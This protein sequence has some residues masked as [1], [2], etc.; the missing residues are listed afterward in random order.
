MS[1]DAIDRIGA[2]E[3]NLKSQLRDAIIRATNTWPAGHPP[4]E[5]LDGAELRQITQAILAIREPLQVLGVQITPLWRETHGRPETVA[6]QIL[7]IV[8][9]NGNS[10]IIESFLKSTNS[11]GTLHNVL[12][13]LRRFAVE[14]LLPGPIAGNDQEAQKTVHNADFTMVVWYGTPHRFALGVQSSAVKALW[15]EWQ[16][17]GL[18]LHGQTIRDAI[19][20]ERDS[21]R[22]DKAFRGH[23][24]Y[25]TMIQAI[26]DGH[27]QLTPPACQSLPASR[28]SE[29]NAK[30]PSKSRRRPL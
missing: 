20:P 23:A 17:T 2:L 27:Y 9:G 7:V 3:L 10:D 6:R 30:S 4:T 24:A 11:E 5:P 25:G 28:K 22:M 8:G 13:S 19:D 1:Q 18:G 16:R 29:K 14:I 26:G 12:F 15:E 21:F